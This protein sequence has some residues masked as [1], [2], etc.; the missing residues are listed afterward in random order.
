M[1][2]FRAELIERVTETRRI[3]KA[4]LK[5]GLMDN[6]EHQVVVSTPSSRERMAAIFRALKAEGKQI[7]GALY[8]LLL[9][10]EPEVMLEMGKLPV[11]LSMLSL[12]RLTQTT[13]KQAYVNTQMHTQTQTD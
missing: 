5:Q 1:Q 4:L 12:M 7:M 9:E 10:H 13:H 6:E 3:A 11:L 2:E 8:R